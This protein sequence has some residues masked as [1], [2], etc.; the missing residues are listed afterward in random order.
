MVYLTDSEKQ[1]LFDIIGPLLEEWIGGKTP[2]TPTSCYGVRAYQGGAV[3]REHYD[4]FGTHIVSAI[5][6]VDQDV[7]APELS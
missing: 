3:L 7:S 1:E 5:M 2:L 4:K 6:Q